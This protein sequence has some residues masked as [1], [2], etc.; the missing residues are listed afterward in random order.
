MGRLPSYFRD[1]GRLGS[2]ASS[3]LTPAP[4]SGD[5]CCFVVL[6]FFQLGRFTDTGGLLLNSKYHNSL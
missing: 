2:N 6:C 4:G 5:R 1:A 3:F